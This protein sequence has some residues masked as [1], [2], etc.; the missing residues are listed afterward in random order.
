M[1]NKYNYKIKLLKL[2]EL[3]STSTDEQHPL[4]TNELI[5]KLEEMGIK[6]ERKTLYEDI[7]LLQDNGYEIMCS[8]DRANRYYVEDRSF[9]VAELRILL[10]SVQSAKFITP[11]KTEEFTT[12][13]AN[14]AGSNRA[15][16]LKRNIVWFDTVKHV[17]EGIYYNIDT[18]N[19]AITEGKK[20]SF[21]YFDYDI[22]GNK[23]YRKEQN[24]YTVSPVALIYTMDNYYLVEYNDKHNS[25]VHYRVDKMDKCEILND[26]ISE[27]AQRQKEKIPSYKSQLFDMFSGEKKVAEFEADISLVD[28][29]LDKFGTKTRMERI[30]D[31]KFRFKVNVHVAPTF[32]AWITTFGKRLKLI[33]DEEIIKGYKA[34]LEEAEANL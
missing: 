1:A 34:F 12:K 14:L 32:Y 21:L 22:T 23:V 6:V 13:I 2:L 8:R 24:R 29:V 33:G 10:D 16:L 30:G 7:K 15:E 18:L 31:D 4:S 9:D 5:W 27:K 17:N 28:V 11:R 19:R 20:A 26:G 25:F 3:L